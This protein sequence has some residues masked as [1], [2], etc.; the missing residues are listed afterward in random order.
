M[1]SHPSHPGYDE[2]AVMWRMRRG[3]GMS[4]HA[5]IGPE[6]GGARVTWYLNGCAVGA[7]D[8]SDWAVALEWTDRMQF[9]NWTVG[10]R[11]AEEADDLAPPESLS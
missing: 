10:W 6:S 9:Q 5:V 4:T 7:R 8:F 1:P 2:P 3:D 11:L